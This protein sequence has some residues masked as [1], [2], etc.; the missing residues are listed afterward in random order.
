MSSRARISRSGSDLAF[1]QEQLLE[2]TSSIKLLKVQPQSGRSP[3]IECTVSTY[4]FDESA[5]YLAI[6]YTWGETEDP[7][8]IMPNAKH[9][10]VRRNL[11]SLLYHLVHLEETGL[12][13]IATV[14]IDQDDVHERSDQVAMMDQIC[15]RAT[16]VIV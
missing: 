11:W 5:S 8:H 9:F 2:S 3:D 6:S 16:S 14:C 13:S 7:K 10:S 15:Q 4:S 1:R 12:F